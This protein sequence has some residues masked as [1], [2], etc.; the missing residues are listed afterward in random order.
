[1]DFSTAGRFTAVATAAVFTYPGGA[2]HWP[3][4]AVKARAVEMYVEG[5]S[6]IAIGRVLE[7]SAP[8]VLGWV[9]KEEGAAYLTDA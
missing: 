9:K 8:A 2:C 6:L 7:Y 5:S 3:G 4:P 1:M